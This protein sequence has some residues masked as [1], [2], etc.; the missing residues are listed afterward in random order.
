MFLDPMMGT[1]VRRKHITLHGKKWRDQGGLREIRELR[2]RLVHKEPHGSHEDELWGRIVEARGGEN[3]PIYLYEQCLLDGKGN[4]VELL[5]V[6]RRHYLVSMQLFEEMAICS[7]YD[8]SM[9]VYTGSDITWHE[10]PTT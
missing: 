3:M 4:K 7:G 9:R 10:I 6:V 2:R 1:L 8:S 5:K